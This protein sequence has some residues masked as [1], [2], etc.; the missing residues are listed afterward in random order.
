MSLE[1]VSPELFLFQLPELMTV[2]VAR[3]E[4][5]VLASL[6]QCLLTIQSKA[7]EGCY[8]SAPQ[9]ASVQS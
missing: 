6:G 3:G 7:L 1:L 2:T 5:V 4:G 9:A 8:F